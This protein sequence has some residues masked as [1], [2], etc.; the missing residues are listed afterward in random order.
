MRKSLAGAV[1][2][3]LAQVAARGF[4]QTQS[5]V[6]APTPWLE[7]AA[8]VGQVVGGA[9]TLGFGVWHFFVPAAFGWYDYLS[10]DPPELEKAIRATNFFFSASLS[11]VGAANVALP[12]FGEDAAAFNRVWLWS[13]VA[14]W[15]SRSVYQAVAPQGTASPALANAML[16]GFIVTDLVFLGAAI[17]KSM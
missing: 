12:L 17:I 8:A 16:A 6:D 15:T 7:S 11:I 9:V 13:M 2:V 10:D 5:S 3:L 14:L 1:A 4:A